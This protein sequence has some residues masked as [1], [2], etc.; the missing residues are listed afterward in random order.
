LLLVVLLVLWIGPLPLT[1]YLR[2]I[3]LF[4][5][6]IDFL[7]V[8][9]IIQFKFRNQKNIVIYAFV[10]FFGLNMVN[11]T[12]QTDTGK[13]TDTKFSR[14][15]IGGKP[16]SVNWL[17]EGFKMDIFPD[18]FPP[19]VPVNI[20]I[21]LHQSNY[22][23]FQL[24]TQVY[25]ITSNYSTSEF[26]ERVEV[27]LTHNLVF[28][29]IPLPRILLFDGD[30]THNKSDLLS[31]PRLSKYYITSSIQ[32]KTNFNIGFVFIHTYNN[33]AYDQVYNVSFYAKEEHD[34]MIVVA[35]VT[36]PGDKLTNLK[37]SNWKKDP[38]SPHKVTMIKDNTD[39]IVKPSGCWNKL[40][41]EEYTQIIQKGEYSFKLQW[42]CLWWPHKT[43]LEL[44]N[45]Q[46]GINAYIYT[47]ASGV[48]V[49]FAHSIILFGKSQVVV[50]FVKITYTVSMISIIRYLYFHDRLLINKIVYTIL[51]LLN[52]WFFDMLKI[53][54]YFT[55]QVQWPL[56]LFGGSLCIY[57][58]FMV[59][60]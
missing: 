58:F 60:S 54:D 25:T 2:A 20:T 35:V 48:V 4:Y 43:Y 1:R 26:F 23:N 10:F 12:N 39:L 37:Y 29:N 45:S 15:I 30:D 46:S 34:Y 17:E 6:S 13:Q 53:T 55:F 22:T 52:T 7:G 33:N 21:S 38:Y 32:M 18:S 57:L 8:C 28:D 16:N 41:S 59:A 27:H 47:N 36:F 51:L 44:N 19:D 9:L 3:I 5:Y 56:I 42:K 24:V 14:I 50:L 49:A 31:L 40:E 11:T